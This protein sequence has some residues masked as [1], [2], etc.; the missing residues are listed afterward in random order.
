MNMFNT[1]FFLVFNLLFLFLQHSYCNGYFPVSFGYQSKCFAMAIT[2]FLIHLNHILGKKQNQP[3]STRLLGKK[4]QANKQKHTPNPQH[5]NLCFPTCMSSIV[6]SSHYQRFIFFFFFYLVSK[7]SLETLKQ[8]FFTSSRL[9]LEL[10]YL[11]PLV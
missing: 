10:S 2:I 7:G 5:F 8:Q 9:F 6:P 4:P 11:E 3:C 1:L